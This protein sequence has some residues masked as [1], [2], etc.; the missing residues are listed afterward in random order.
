MNDDSLNE[1]VF[2][3]LDTTT[4]TNTNITTLQRQSKSFRAS[5]ATINYTYDEEPTMEPAEEMKRSASQESGD[6]EFDATTT[7]YKIHRKLLSLMSNPQQFHDA[8][9]WIAKIEK[10]IDPFHPGGA[11][12]AEKEGLEFEKEDGTHNVRTSD[13]PSSA[14]DSKYPAQSR[15]IPPLP[16]QIFASDAEVVL[17]EAMTASQLFGIERVTGIELEAAAGIVGLSALFLRWLGESVTVRS[18]C[19]LVPF[20]HVIFDTLQ[21]FTPGVHLPALMPEGDHMNIIDPPGLTVMRIAGGRYR[22]TGSHRVVWRWMN[23]FSPASTFNVPQDSSPYEGHTQNEREE[24]ENKDT[25]FDFGD[26]VTMTIIDV[27][28]TDQE[29]KLLSYCPTFDNRAV[30]RTQEVVERVKKGASNLKERVD[31]V[32]KSP[33]GQKALKVRYVFILLIRLDTRTFET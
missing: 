3:A 6:G 17:P 27:F 22:V 16:I 28:E 14:G 21:N 8:I 32:V 11:S 9:D 15:L 2:H 26:L 1:S 25:D 4:I 29:G 13:T 12:E 33:T 19:Y 24:N 23:K 7:I 20:V 5:T 30:H 18:S 10:G 31:V